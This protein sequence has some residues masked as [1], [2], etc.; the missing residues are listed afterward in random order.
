MRVDK[1]MRFEYGT[2]E[3]KFLTEKK[4]LQIQKYPDRGELGL[5]L[6]EVSACSFVLFHNC[7]HV[8]FE[9]PT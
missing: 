1:P 8:Y 3:E 4:K 9:K 7:G 5:R 6:H 2:C